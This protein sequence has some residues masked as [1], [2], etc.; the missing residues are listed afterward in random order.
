MVST[1]TIGA[2]QEVTISVDGGVLCKKFDEFQRA[3]K[4]II[5]MIWRHNSTRV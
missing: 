1:N 4:S 3:K 5:L 2:I